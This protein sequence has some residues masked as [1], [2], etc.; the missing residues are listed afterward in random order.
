MREFFSLL[1]RFLPTS[2]ALRGL[3]QTIW[4]LTKGGWRALVWGDVADGMVNLRGATASLRTL[5]RAALLLVLLLLL[6]LLFND[7]WRAISPLVPVSFLSDMPAPAMAPRLLIPLTLGLMALAW[8]Y[9]LTGALHAPWWLRLAFLAVYGVDSFFGLAFGSVAGIGALL[10]AMELLA[11]LVLLLI[12]LLRWRRRPRPGLEF[13]LILACVAA[14]AAANYLRAWRV[15]L[16]YNTTQAW[17]AALVSSQTQFVGVFLLPF[18]LIAGLEV[19]ELAIDVN[20]LV[21]DTLRDINLPSS[22]ITGLLA[23]GL[24][25]RV[26]AMWVAPMLAGQGLPFQPGA[27]I[28]LGVLALLALAVRPRL[29]EET[30][31]EWAPVV[32]AF[33]FFGL[34]LIVTSVLSVAG[35]TLMWVVGLGGSL[36]TYNRGM[37]LLDRAINLVTNNNELVVA[38]LALIWG[39]WLALRAR[40]Q[41]ASQARPGE[42]TA[43]PVA[44]PIPQLALYAWTFGLWLI[45]WRLT[46]PGRPLSTWRFAY[47]E[48]DVALTVVVLITLIVLWVRRRLTPSRLWWLVS[49]GLL[50]ALLRVQ[51]FLSDPLSPLFGLLGAQALFI[52]VGVFLGLMSAGQRFQLNESSRRLPRPNRILLYFG[53]ALFSVTVTNWLWATHQIAQIELTDQTAQNGFLVVGLPLAL[54]VLVQHSRPTA[55]DA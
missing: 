38:V 18:F 15:E 7:F 49:A 12:F 29:A 17:T 2:R 47:E 10:L 50:A 20:D 53:Y 45:W 8:A 46:R 27:W 52:S 36:V 39:I 48:I 3:G 25:V 35:G 6:S 9:M 14:V 5:V 55:A 13:P 51:D 28:I 42:A 32:I 40:R 31:P 54:L 24:L 44:G 23:G 1:L 26:G 43:D 33:L 16:D 34:V 30:L 11:L 37:G 19:A 41:A 21:T 22:L 4:V